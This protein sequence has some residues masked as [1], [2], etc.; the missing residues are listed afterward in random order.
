MARRHPPDVVRWFRVSGLRDDG[1]SNLISLCQR[2]FNTSLCSDHAARDRVRRVTGG[3]DLPKALATHLL[4]HPSQIGKARHRI[5]RHRASSCPSW[6]RTRTLLI[7]SPLAQAGISDNLL[8][9]G[10]FPSIGA[11]IPAVVCPLVP[12]ETTAKLRQWSLG[13]GRT[14]LAHPKGRRLICAPEPFTHPSGV[15]GIKQFDKM[16]FGGGDTGFLERAGLSPN[17]LRRAH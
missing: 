3:H 5:I 13:V 15:G 1:R 7:Q 8:G 9:V 4:T 11:R 16:S 17:R 14:G 12:G 2:V 6:A 10:H